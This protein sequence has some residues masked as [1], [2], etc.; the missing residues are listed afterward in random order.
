MIYVYIDTELSEVELRD[1]KKKIIAKY[2]NISS[3]STSEIISSIKLLMFSLNK[4][5][6][7]YKKYNEET[8]SFHI[9]D[10]EIMKLIKTEDDDIRIHIKKS[11]S[12]CLNHNELSQLGN[13][14]NI[15]NRITS[16]D[17]VLWDKAN[18][19]P[20]KIKIQREELNILQSECDIKIQ[21]ILHEIQILNEE[22]ITEE[23]ALFYV[24][25]IREIRQYR[26]KIKTKIK[27]LEKEE[28]R[29]FSN[30]K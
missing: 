13:F 12:K 26:N 5:F 18:D 4:I 11:W 8:Y 21:D 9:T 1:N 15:F 19:I 28:K 6:D 16:K 20:Y 27:F 30:K 23:K 7:R 2:S 29:Y 10:K 24:L 25:K 3:N 22:H 17:I 14:L